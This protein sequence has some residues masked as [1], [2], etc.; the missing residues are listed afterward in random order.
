VSRVTVIAA[1]FAMIVAPPRARGGPAGTE[2][3]ST[4]VR[5]RYD[6]GLEVTSADGN[7]RAHIDWR[8]QLRFTDSSGHG[9]RTL[10]AEL[11]AD[12]FRVTRARFKLGGHAYRPWLA[13][14]LEYDLP[15]TRLLDLRLTLRHGGAL[16]L[17]VGQ[18]KVPYNRERVDSSGKQQF[19]ER[20]IVNDV[21]TIDRQQGLLVFGR[22]GA[23]TRMDSW[24]NIGVYTGNGRGGSG[25]DAQPMVSARYQWNFLGRDL[26][27]SQSDIGY[28]ER[29]AGSLA[30]AGVRNRSAYTAFSSAGGGQLPGFED[31]SAGRYDVMQ[32]VIETAFQYRGWSWQQETHW[33]SVEDREAATTTDL[34]GGYA[35]LGLFPHALLGALPRPLEL[36]VRYAR[37]DPSSAVDDDRRD[38]LTLAG[39]WFFA[40]HRNKL[41]V[42]Y[43]H[44]TGQ[45]ETEQTGH[46]VRVQWDISF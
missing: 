10:E 46:R 19:V 38:E 20:S 32:A 11:R 7:F 4:E 45:G 28:R 40:G 8:A 39:N 25:D 1:A 14:Y 43:A 17:R 41:T 34:Q 33:K 15:S 22:L 6:K 29:A 42:D 13:Y 35:Q 27:F 18:W 5:V 21:F 30:V 12:E 44:L 2:D 36:A 16:Q 23:G 37:V 26:G 9:P 31:G 24:Y 3:P